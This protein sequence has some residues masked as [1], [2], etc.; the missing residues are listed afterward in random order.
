MQIY[1]S[2]TL[3]F[4]V[5]LIKLWSLSAAGLWTVHCGSKG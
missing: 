3:A 1:T 5:V 4:R 2:L